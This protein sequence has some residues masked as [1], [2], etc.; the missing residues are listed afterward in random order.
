MT[1]LVYTDNNASIAASIP[2]SVGTLGG[3]SPSTVSCPSRSTIVADGLRPTNENRLHR[4]PCS[5]DSSRKP[6]S[7]PTSLAKAATGVSRSPSTSPQT[8]TTVC[9]P[10]RRWNSSRVG[11]TF[12]AGSRR[13]FAERAEEARAGAGVARARTLLLDEEQKRVAVA[14]VVRLADVLAV[15]TG[16]ALAPQLLATARPVDHPPFLERA[17]QRFG[18]HPRHHQHLARVD[19]LCD[20]GD[21]PVGVE[22]DTGELFWRGVDA[23]SGR[24]ASNSRDR[25]RCWLRSVWRRARA[26]RARAA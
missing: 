10:A 14:V 5:T 12:T 20:R 9:S 8:G 24:H 7:C 2:R 3:R 22:R 16:V 15:A 19:V 26:G 23:H 1:G 11:R 21:Q 6:G 17:A 4:S 18:V 25:G 13:R